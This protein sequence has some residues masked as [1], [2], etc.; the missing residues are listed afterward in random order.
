MKKILVASCVLILFLVFL[1][2][3]F[4]KSDDNGVNESKDTDGDGYPDSEDDFPND[5]NLH[6]KILINSNDMNWQLTVG[7]W[8][9]VCFWI[10]NAVTPKEAKYV[11][12][13]M[14]STSDIQFFIECPSGVNPNYLYDKVTSNVETQYYLTEDMKDEWRVWG[15]NDGDI[16][17]FV[18]IRVETW[19]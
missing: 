5:S 9:H 14:S 1:T 3:C 19:V 4:E 16:T 7:E 10:G 13:K 11:Y 17:S 2:G 15:R 6:K 18:N 8:E 12:V